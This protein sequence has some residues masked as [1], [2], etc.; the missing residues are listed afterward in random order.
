MGQKLEKQNRT[1]ARKYS[2]ID[3]DINQFVNNI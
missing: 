2:E 3:I 1:F